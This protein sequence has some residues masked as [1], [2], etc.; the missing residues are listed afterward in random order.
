MTCRIL[1]GHGWA[2]LIR[3]ADPSPG[4]P[5]ILAPLP[6]WFRDGAAG[7]A[8]GGQNGFIEGAPVNKPK[9]AHGH[10]ALT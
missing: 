10:F 8:A 6:S 2:S 9:V 1:D 5:R 4:A 3:R 7:K